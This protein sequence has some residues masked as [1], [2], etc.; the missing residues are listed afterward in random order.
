M[1]LLQ[2][3]SLKYAEPVDRTGDTSEMWMQQLSWQMNK[4]LNVAGLSKK[5]GVP[6]GYSNPYAYSMPV[7]EGGMSCFR[8]II[9]LGE[10]KETTNLTRAKTFP[11]TTIIG[12]GT[13][14]EPSLT[15]LV[16]LACEINGFGEITDGSVLKAI[17]NMSAE[18]EGHGEIIDS[19]I[20]SLIAW[21][22]AECIGTGDI[23]ATMKG[24]AYME[25]VI[26]SYGDLSVEGLRDAVWTAIASKYVNPLTMGGKLNS[27]AVGGVDYDALAEAVL[28]AEVTGR[29]V[30]SLGKTIEDTKKKA[31]MIPGLY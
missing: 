19:S 4:Y 5:S 30:G 1:G 12:S 13:I 2:N 22:T 10:V 23:E 16:Q 18:L 27:A 31:N 15:L 8:G 28:D 7:K 3:I 6:D 11:T 20:L 14:H 29:A 25:T 26:K 21:C 9:G 24:I 17:A